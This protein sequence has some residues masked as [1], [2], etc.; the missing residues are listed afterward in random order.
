MILD[1]TYDSISYPISMNMPII[2]RK[3]GSGDGLLPSDNKALAELL[4][5]NTLVD[6]RHHLE[7]TNLFGTFYAFSSLYQSSYFVSIL[8][9]LLSTEI[10]MR[11]VYGWVIASMVTSTERSIPKRKI[12]MTR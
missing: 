2:S 9:Y 1:V 4:L 8:G 12:V 11:H 10:K 3:F 6:I 7:V 5:T